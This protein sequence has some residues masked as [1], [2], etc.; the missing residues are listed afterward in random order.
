VDVLEQLLAAGHKMRE[1][2]EARFA[3]ISYGQLR[4]ALAHLGRCNPAPW[5]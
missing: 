4:L 2:K 1:L 5:E 3:D